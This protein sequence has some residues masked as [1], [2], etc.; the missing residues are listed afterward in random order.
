[1]N[2]REDIRNYLRMQDEGRSTGEIAAALGCTADQARDAL[3]NMRAPGSVGKDDLGKWYWDGG[4][5]LVPEGV[6]VRREPPAKTVSRP[7]SVEPQEIVELAE[8]LD[9]VAMVPAEELEKPV[10]APE[11]EH[12]VERRLTGPGSVARRILLLV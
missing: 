12:R 10:P 4:R 7:L 6:A 1:M 3:K 5:G 2:R 11:P 8:H 9:R